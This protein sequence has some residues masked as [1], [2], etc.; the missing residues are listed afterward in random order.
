MRFSLECGVVDSIVSVEPFKATCYGK[1][2]HFIPN[3][4]GVLSKIKIIAGTDH[5]EKFF[6]SVTPRKDDPE[7]NEIYFSADMDH[8]HEL[9]TSDFQ[10]LEGVLAMRRAISK[11]NWQSAI[12]EYL[13]ETDEERQKIAISSLKIE[14]KIQYPPMQFEMNDFGQILLR[15]DF[16]GRLLNQ[17]LTFFREGQNDWNEGRFINSFF[18]FYFILEG[19]FSEKDR[20]RNFET[21]EDFLASPKFLEF[22]D[23]VINDEFSAGSRL[24]W[25]LDKM[26]ANLTDSKGQPIP[27]SCDAEGI[28]WLLVDT[29]GNLLHFKPDTS[30]PTAL[31]RF[32]DDYEA[33]ATLAYRIA[34]RAVAYFYYEQVEKEFTKIM[35]PRKDTVDCFLTRLPPITG[36]PL[37]Q[38]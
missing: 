3:D 30:N 14:R 20:W 8:V 27:K 21:R 1:E 36:Q 15:R 31:L 19:S 34:Q 10:Y 32:D 4:K 18:N 12:L 24:R 38:G 6:V 25:W 23:E 5:P 7:G 9:L 33:I 22:L 26:L 29:R 35:E 2:Y 28:A 11:I 37:D 13:P 17:F 16:H